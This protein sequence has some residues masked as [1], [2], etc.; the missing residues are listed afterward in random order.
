MDELVSLLKDIAN[1]SNQQ[2]VKGMTETERKQMCT[3]GHNLRYHL[4]GICK[5]KCRCK[6]FKLRKGK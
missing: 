6:G 2:F 1:S 5:Y 4:N 3:C